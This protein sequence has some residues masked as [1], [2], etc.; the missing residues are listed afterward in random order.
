MSRTVI[1]MAR[2]PRAAAER[3]MV[4][5]GRVERAERAERAG[6]VERGWARVFARIRAA[7]AAPVRPQAGAARLA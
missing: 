2:V 6:R 1:G 7:G 3:E 4:V 5:V